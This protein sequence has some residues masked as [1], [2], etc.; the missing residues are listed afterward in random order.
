MDWR[1]EQAQVWLQNLRELIDRQR[2][3]MIEF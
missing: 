1:I 3:M 2:D